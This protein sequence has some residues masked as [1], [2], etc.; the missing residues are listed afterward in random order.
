MTAW[1]FDEEE[2]RQA[3]MDK[4]NEGKFIFICQPVPKMESSEVIVITLGFRLSTQNKN[5]PVCL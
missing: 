4:T 1:Y 2:R 5:I 3:K